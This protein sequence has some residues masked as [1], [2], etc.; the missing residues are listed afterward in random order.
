M[1][2]KFARLRIKD[3][4]AHIIDVVL[5]NRDEQGYINFSSA[6]SENGAV[7]YFENYV[8]RSLSSARHYIGFSLDATERKTNEHNIRKHT[9]NLEKINKELNQFAYIISHDLKTPL[10]AI[11]NLSEWI[12]EDLKDFDDGE[13][14][15]NLQLLRTRVLR[16]E[17]LIN[18]ILN[19]S[20]A[21]RDKVIDRDVDVAK[22]IRETA[23]MVSMPK[24]FRLKIADNIPKID[25]NKTNLER[26]FMH[27]ISNAIKHHDKSRGTVSIEYHDSG[28]YHEFSVA[29]DGP[30]ILL[31][32]KPYNPGILSKARELG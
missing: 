17:N 8:F 28:G 1:S 26:V 4:L 5:K 25:F 21:T 11:T 13:V 3:N 12:E 7:Q 6:Y 22:L 18:G 2:S 24:N 15:E 20:R 27:L 29:D 32:F 14:K 9:K 16:F 10:R 19:Y 23:A 31:S 30:G